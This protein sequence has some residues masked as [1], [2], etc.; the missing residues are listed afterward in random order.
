MLSYYMSIWNNKNKF[1]KQKSLVSFLTMTLHGK[2]I[3]KMFGI[4]GRQNSK[5]KLCGRALRM[6][7]FWVC[8]VFFIYPYFT[9]RVV[10]CGR[11]YRI[12]LDCIIT[13]QKR[14]IQI[15][16]GVHSLTH[17]EPVFSRLKILKSIDLVDYI[18][19]IFMYKV[20]HHY[21]PKYLKPITLITATPMIKSPDKSIIYTLPMLIQTDAIR[22]CGFREAKSGNLL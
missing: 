8:T 11:T 16:V 21:V 3:S 2:H 18:I 13:L 10:V 17:T 9:Y 5:K 1:Q 14:V 22:L 20:Y 15:F 19:G 7:P 6:T 4:K 12:D